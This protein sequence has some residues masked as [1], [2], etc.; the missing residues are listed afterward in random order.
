MTLAAIPPAWGASDTSSA[1][2]FEKFIRPL[3]T[4]NCYKCHSAESEKIKGGLRLDTRDGIRQGGDTGPAVVPGDPE[5]S[6]LIK[7]VRY[8]DENLQMPPKGKK[9]TPAQVSTLEEWVKMG[10]PDPRGKPQAPIATAR[11]EK[12]WAFQPVQSPAIPAVKNKAWVKTPIDNFILSKLEAARLAPSAPADKRTLI[13]RATFD[14]TGLPP[15]PAE[16]EDFLRDNSPEAFAR[17]V[18]R[19]L[20]SPHYGERWGRYWLDVARYADT[21]GYVFEEERRYPYAY[22]YRDYVIRAFN[23]DLPYDQFIVEQIAADQ[24]PLGDDKRPLAAL[25]YLTLGR[26]FLNNVPDIIDDRIDVVSRGMMGLT[27]GCARCHDHKFDPIPTK[28]YYSLYGV[29]NSSHEPTDQPLL[30]TNSLPREY[31]EY[32]AERQKRTEEK[33]TFQKT[34][35]AEALN[36]VRD[37]VGDYLLAV[38]DGETLGDDKIDG[39][40]RERKLD[41]GVARR[42]RSRLAEIKNGHDPIFEPWVTLASLPAEGFSNAAPAV[43]G[44]L[45]ESNAVIRTLSTNSFENLKAV[46]LAYNRIFSEANH[47]AEPTPEQKPLREFLLGENS[48]TS[49]SNQEIKRLFDVQGSQRLRALQRKIDELDATHPGAPPKAMA[50]LDNSSPSQARV[51]VRGNPANPGPNV[52]RQMLQIVAGEKRQPFSQ[53]SGRLELARALAS[54]DNPLTPRVIVNRIWLHHFARG[55][56]TT[57]SDFGL[58]SDPPSHPE[59][60]DY[61]ATYLMKNDWSLKSLHRLILLSST[62]QQS[63][64]EAPARGGKSRETIDPE[65]RLLSKFPRQRL[66]FE[67]MRDSLLF[68]SGQLDSTIGGHAVDIVKDSPAPRRTIYGFIDRQ[69]LP[70]LFRTF[71]FASPDSSSP[72]R[73][74]TSIP[75]QALFLLNSPFVVDQARNLLG[76]PG[77]KDLARDE[78]KLDWLYHEVVQRAPAEDEIKM[79]LQFL[80]SQDVPAT[81]GEKHPGPWEKYAQVLLLSNEFAFVD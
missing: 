2:F 52:P 16:V 47:A 35:T 20:A 66:D 76:K 74:Y 58:R 12:H 56:V 33:E 10:A 26:R 37:H 80:K 29:F 19:L 5:K 30:G 45:G 63:S 54:R 50:L 77:F 14:L 62:Y 69:N 9:L 81:P 59:L 64:S 24:L 22:T 44:R 75:Q 25:G 65:N 6:L 4:E 21:K 1:D 41:P 68:V 46:S 60:L 28:D 73:F 34:K 53:G 67:S 3:L 27:T 55:I 51:F 40:V 71:D 79:A 43:L 72:Q 36:L 32:L 38:H 8:S 23:E 42:W 70:G 31:P 61:L 57:P 48:P 49:L 13:R 7:A 78:E 39:L 18:D 15:T 11:K 17:V